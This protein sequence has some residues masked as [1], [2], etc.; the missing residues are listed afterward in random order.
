MSAFGTFLPKAVSPQTAPLKALTWRIGGQGSSM[1]RQ[2]DAPQLGHRSTV[3]NSLKAA[4][5]AI[6]LRSPGRSPQCRSGPFDAWLRRDRNGQLPGCKRKCL[7]NPQRARAHQSLRQFDQDTV[8]SGAARV[9]WTDCHLAGEQI[10]RETCKKSRPDSEAG[11]SAPKIR[12]GAVYYS[13]AAT[14]SMP[15]PDGRSY[16]PWLRPLRCSI[17]SPDGR[18][19][20]YL[21]CMSHRL[22]A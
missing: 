17:T 18:T 10:R 3:S 4:P 8:N 20:A 5:K 21:A 11:T 12:R 2:A 14:R 19:L 9:I 1:T 13:A 22:M 15:A 16:M 7:A 6:N